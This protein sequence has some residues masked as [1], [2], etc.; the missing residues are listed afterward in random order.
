MN[1][2]DALPTWSA[3]AIIHLLIY[4]A[5]HAFNTWYDRDEQPVGLI[6]TPPPVNASLIWTAWVLDAAAVI[7]SWFVGP[8]FFAAMV[9]YTLGS[10]LYSWRVTRWKKYP[11]RGWAGVGVVQGALTYLA[12]VQG[13]GHGLPWADVRVWGGAVTAALFL[14]GVFPL[15]QVYQHEEDERHGDMTISRLVGIR[16]TFVLS[17]AFLTATMAAFTVLFVTL[18]GWPTALLLLGIQTPTLV[19]FLWWA[20][21]VWRDQARA[22]FGRTMGMN[23]MAAGLMN[24]FF[25]I[26]ILGDLRIWNF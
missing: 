5:S 21:A 24:A 2:S 1:P 12:V 10:K 11:I 15:T 16:G 20:V 25:I 14:W 3:F 26:V 23:A 8:L 6:K 17:G 9:L 18:R 19:Y 7:W 4:P 13:L 22:D